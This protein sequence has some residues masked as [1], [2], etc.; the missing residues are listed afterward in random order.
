MGGRVRNVNWL[1][2]QVGYTGVDGQQGPR[3]LLSLFIFNFI[4]KTDGN[5][6]VANLFHRVTTNPI[7]RQRTTQT[8]PWY[9]SSIT[10][11]CTIRSCCSLVW[12]LSLALT[13][14]LDQ[15]DGPW[16]RLNDRV[17]QAAHSDCHSPWEIASIFLLANTN[18]VKH[19]RGARRTGVAVLPSC[20]WLQASR[21]H[22]PVIFSFPLSF[23]GDSRRHCGACMKA[24]NKAQTKAECQ[25]C[26]T[27][28]KVTH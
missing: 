26:W 7:A 10:P 6:R 2:T 23:A 4:D 8:P 5:N 18:T 3:P 21:N 9:Y 19:G 25:R 12:G 11:G 14:G 24:I 27:G 15:L 16:L 22:F 1:V 13:A 28:S 17:F 20:S